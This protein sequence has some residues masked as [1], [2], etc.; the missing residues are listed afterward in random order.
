MGASVGKTRKKAGTENRKMS[1]DGIR[2]GRILAI[3]LQ[4]TGER[5]I[6]DR[7]L[8]KKHVLMVPLERR[9]LVLLTGERI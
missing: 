5:C 9:K 3:A 2:L 1:D 6:S 7:M 8:A 4:S